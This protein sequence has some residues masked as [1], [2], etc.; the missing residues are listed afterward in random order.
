MP[1]YWFSFVQRHG[2]IGRELSVP[3]ECDC[4]GVGAEIEILDESGI[5]SEQSDLYPGIAVA[6]AGYVP[7]GGCNIGTGDP[8]FISTRDGEGG[9]LYRIYH[10]EVVD[11]HFDATKAI[12]VVLKDYRELL[13]YL[14]S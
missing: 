11:E 5:Q 1:P 12:V 3:E 14:N 6:E 10:D 4:S 2:L 9:P 7:V 13:N 8:Y